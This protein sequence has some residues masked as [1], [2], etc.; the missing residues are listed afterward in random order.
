MNALVSIIVPIYNTEVYLAI[1]VQSIIMQS[2]KNIEIILLNDGSTDA[3]F[4]ICKKLAEKD[5]R[6]KVV[7]NSNH[8]VSFTRN[9]GLKIAKG[10][11]VAFIDS[12]DAIHP[13][14][15]EK[16]IAPLINSDLN[17]SVC[18]YQ[19]VDNFRN[20][21]IQ[22]KRQVNNSNEIKNVIDDFYELCLMG[23]ILY[24]PWAKIYKKE[25]ID[26]Y[27]ILFDERISNGEDQLFN[28]LYY[29]HVEK[30]AFINEKLYFYNRR[31]NGLSKTKTKKS[32]E[33]L[34]KVRETLIS[35][36]Q[37]YHVSHFAGII[38]EHCITDLADYVS[39]DNDGY[40]QY[41]KRVQKVK[42]YINGK[43]EGYG[44]K[45]S[46]L[47]FLLRHSIYFPIYL[48]YKFKYN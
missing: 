32:L 9:L 47:F 15:I 25:I 7:N 4:A 8:G 5:K 24:G 13:Y 44:I 1:C 34:Y 23:G 33:D 19:Y 39:V 17:L 20:I 28:F 42:K 30:I 45:K 16:L 6:I 31:D 38:C 35:F 2:Y 22:E 3:S 37:E 48:Y 43:Y 26:K 12:D 40:T 14:Y 46:V 10:E 41:K 27:H 11:F 21:N 36:L 18:R 29:Q